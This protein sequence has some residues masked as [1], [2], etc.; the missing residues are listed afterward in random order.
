MRPGVSR[1]STITD[2][3]R[4]RARLARRE[5]N[6]CTA[7][8][9]PWRVSRRASAGSMSWRSWFRNVTRL[10]HAKNPGQAE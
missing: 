1:P 10:E 3:P 6:G 2:R 8:I 9:A 4:L 5:A 7:L